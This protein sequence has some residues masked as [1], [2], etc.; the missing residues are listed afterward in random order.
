M[1]E[2]LYLFHDGFS[3]KVSKKFDGWFQTNMGLLKCSSVSHVPVNEPLVEHKSGGVGMA[4]ETMMCA[5]G[6]NYGV[7]W[8]DK[9][10]NYFWNKSLNVNV[11]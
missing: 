9:P 2:Q 11:L 3:R 10:E 7:Y 4:V 5:D 8:F 6:L 1:K